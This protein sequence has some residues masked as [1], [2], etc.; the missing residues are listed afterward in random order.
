MT[1]TQAQTLSR[2]ATT[3]AAL[4]ELVILGFDFDCCEL[5]NAPAAELF[6][7]TDESG[8]EVHVCENCANT[9]LVGC[10]DCD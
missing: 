8:T 2:I 6:W 7:R 10:F 3:T 1:R 4:A 9:V 5:C